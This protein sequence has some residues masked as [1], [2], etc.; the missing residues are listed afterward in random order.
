[1]S[2]D[3]P[4]AS[5][6]AVSTD[7]VKSTTEKFAEFVQWVAELIQKRN[8]FTLLLLLDV[9]LFFGF[10]QEGGII[11][12]FFQRFFALDLPLWYADVFWMVLA[13]IFFGAIAV[14]VKTMPRAAKLEVQEGGERKVIKGL[15]SFTAEDAD[16]FEK[17][18]RSDAVAACLESL[19]RREFRFGVLMGE[20]GCGKTSFCRR[21]CCQS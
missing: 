14:A 16:M 19:Q 3:Q 5:S 12:G 21:A 8:W 10:K 11:I 1:M 13:G 4:P 20:S 18:Q 17:L 7:I 6:T 15:R 2:E 9:A